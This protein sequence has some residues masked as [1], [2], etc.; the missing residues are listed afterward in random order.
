MDLTKK[1]EAARKKAE[2][3]KAR[4]QALEARG[5]Q[6]ERKRDAKR[7]IV[8]G[9]LL[10]DWAGKDPQA[11]QFLGALLNRVVREQDLKAFE[12]WEPPTPSLGVQ[13]APQAAPPAP[14]SA[15]VAPNTVPS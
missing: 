14:E 1:I 3:A 15:P 4:L 13:P 5:S 9:G 7:K 10:L 8:L 11:A 12:G 6:I 2:Q